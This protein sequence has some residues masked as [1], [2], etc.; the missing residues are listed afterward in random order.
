MAITDTG[1]LVRMVQSGFIDEFLLPKP[2][3]GRVY[4]KPSPRESQ[5][6]PR[7]YRQQLSRASTPGTNLPAQVIPITTNPSLGCL[8][9]HPALHSGVSMH[10]IGDVAFPVFA[11]QSVICEL[12]PPRRSQ[13]TTRRTVNGK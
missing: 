7:N 10:L 5:H 12:E 6:S 3:R 9:A 13:H 1:A 2:T 8:V 11:L 4:V